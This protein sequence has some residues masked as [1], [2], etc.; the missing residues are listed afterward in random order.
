MGA[1][2]RRRRGSCGPARPF[3]AARTLAG[4]LLGLACAVSGA[5]PA[6]RLAGIFGDHM[7]LQRGQPLVVWGEAAAGERLEVSFAGS[8]RRT[9]AGPDGRWQVRLPAQEAGGPHRLQVRSAAAM[10]ERVDVLVGDLWLCAG[11]SNMEWTVAQSADAERQTAAAHAPT[12]RHAKLLPRQSLRPLDDTGP[13]AWRA[14]SPATVGA[15]TAVGYYFARAL[16][17]EVPVPIGLIDV[18][19]GGSHLETWSSPA[20]LRA[21]ASMRAA[22]KALPADE[23]AFA[24]AVRRR[25]HGMARRWQGDRWAASDSQRED[26]DDAD[27]PL[28]SLP[29]VWEQRGLDGFDG[30]VWF[31]REVDLDTAQ[32]QSPAELLLGPVDDCDD[33]WVNGVPVGQTCGWDQPR[34]YALPAG[35][36]RPGR[37]RLAVRV[38]DTGGDG[39]LHGAAGAMMLRTA[40]GEVALDGPWRVMA[41][42]ALDK[43]SPGFND[44]PSLLFNAMIHPLTRLPLRGVL[45]YQGESNVPRAARYGQAFKRMITDWRR[46]WGQSRLPFLFVQLPAF[47]EDHGDRRLPSAWA[48][49]REAQA[50]A[51]ALPA[52]AMA[53]ALDLGDARDIHPRDKRSVGERLARLAARDL[54][55][56][57]VAA[58]GPMIEAVRWRRDGSVELSF[59]VPAGR[60]LARAGGREVRGFVLAGADR[61][62]VPASARIDGRRVIVRS[63][64]VRRPTALRYAWADNPSEADLIDSNGMPAAPMR[65]DDWPLSTRAARLVFP[66]Q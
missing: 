22:L 55:K 61:Q 63:E 65:T 8:R 47:L 51:L 7:V 1:L 39:G 38:R 40:A 54:F 43:T 23:D 5:Q 46:R 31:R 49:L 45:W 15:F 48:E 36:L 66:Y 42:S 13:V 64:Q 62:F 32:A 57:P 34:R 4:V 60:L 3:P 28:M 19:R 25:Q 10:I 41:E 30:V 12:I 53:V 21:D 2:S 14:A 29:G 35:V 9:R 33:T 58:G 6:L 16:Q 20:A 50:R 52:T 24:R 18:A 17:R 59:G 26:L 11:Q 27:W 44:G 37:N 56:L